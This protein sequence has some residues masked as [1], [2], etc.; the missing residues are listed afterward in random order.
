LVYRRRHQSSSRTFALLSNLAPQSSRSGQRRGKPLLEA[1]RAGLSP[2][3]TATG[4]TA[5]RTYAAQS[6]GCTST[7]YPSSMTYVHRL[8]QWPPTRCR[9]DHHRLS[10]PHRGV[11]VA[12][13]RAISARR[14]TAA[15]RPVGDRPEHVAPVIE[16]I[17]RSPSCCVSTP[18]TSRRAHRHTRPFRSDPA[19]TCVDR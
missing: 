15:P 18:R 9:R 6:S 13:E 5:R 10:Q 17:R 2:G 19:R 14:R 12:T 1:C 3:A 11:G 16:I 4:Q 7:P 8:A